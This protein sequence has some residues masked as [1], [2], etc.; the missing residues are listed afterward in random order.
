MIGLGACLILLLVLLLFGLAFLFALLYSSQSRLPG[1]AA[2]NQHSLTPPNLE[3]PNP[4]NQR[5]TG[6]E[7]RQT[8]EDPEL[9]GDLLDTVGRLCGAHLYQSYLNIGLLADSAARG[10]YELEDAKK[11]LDSVHGLLDTVEGQLTP[12]DK[13]SLSDDDR[14]H[15]AKIRE[16]SKII[17]VQARELKTY[18]EADEGAKELHSKQYEKARDASWAALSELFGSATP[19]EPEKDKAKEE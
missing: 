17:R 7:P 2:A 5:P 19:A 14:K 10:V 1:P 11:W 12:L 6:S 4:S 18:W 8:T 16:V 3:L 15:L 13:A 9:V